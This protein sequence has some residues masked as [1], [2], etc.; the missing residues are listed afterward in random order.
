MIDKT[1][2]FFVST[3]FCYLFFW[4]G[5]PTTRTIYLHGDWLRYVNDPLIYAI[6][7]PIII[8]IYLWL[9]Y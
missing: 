5:V 7:T 9:I 3:T 2:L 1:K 4:I 8:A 6:I